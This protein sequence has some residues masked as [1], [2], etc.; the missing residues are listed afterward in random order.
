M[1]TLQQRTGTIKLAQRTGTVKLAQRTGI[2]TF[3]VGNGQPITPPVYK[4]DFTKAY[5][6]QYINI[7]F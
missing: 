6:S 3:T 5:N 4:L 2:C 1:I 7:I